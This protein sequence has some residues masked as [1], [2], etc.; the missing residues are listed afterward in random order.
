MIGPFDEM[1]LQTAFKARDVLVLGTP[2]QPI[3]KARDVERA[4]GYALKGCKP[5]R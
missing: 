2:N 3:F 5:L 1:D 4:L